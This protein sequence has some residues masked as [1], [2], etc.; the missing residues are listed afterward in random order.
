[1]KQQKVSKLPHRPSKYVA[2]LSSFPGGPREPTTNLS[3]NVGMKVPCRLLRLHLYDHAGIAVVGF[4]E[5][6]SIY[7]LLVS[8]VFRK[9]LDTNLRAEY[10]SPQQG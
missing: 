3:A 1:M 10:P 7:V 5:L 4:W 8:G 9:L 2:Y 6:S